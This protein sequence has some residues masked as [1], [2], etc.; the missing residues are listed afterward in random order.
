MLLLKFSE[1]RLPGL[2]GFL[3]VQVVCFRKSTLK[4]RD[5]QLPGKMCH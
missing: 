5:C 1:P 2:L 3:S 4:F